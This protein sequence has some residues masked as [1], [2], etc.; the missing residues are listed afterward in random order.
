MAK[1]F[2]EKWSGDCKCFPML[3]ATANHLLVRKPSEGKL[4]IR[5]SRRD[6]CILRPAQQPSDTGFGRAWRKSFS[7]GSFP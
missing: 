3:Y 5:S 6:F 1:N 2:R 7:A 4:Q